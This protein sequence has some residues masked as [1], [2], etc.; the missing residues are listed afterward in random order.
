MNYN[1]QGRFGDKPP[2]SLINYYANFGGFRRLG[3]LI[4]S[5]VAAGEAFITI[6]VVGLW[7]ELIGAGVAA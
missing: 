3:F 2:V 5:G 1:G 4:H 6:R 7:L